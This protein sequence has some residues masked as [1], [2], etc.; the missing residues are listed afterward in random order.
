MGKD[1]KWDKIFNDLDGVVVNYYD[2]KIAEV[3]RKGW[4][5][6]PF[7][8]LESSFKEVLFL[9]SDICPAKDPGYLFDYEPYREKGSIFWGFYAAN[10]IGYYICC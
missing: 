7:A 9:D 4:S 8:I 6:K 3:D 5:L 2:K 1:D 10:Y